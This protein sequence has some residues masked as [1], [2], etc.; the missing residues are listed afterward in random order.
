MVRSGGLQLPGRDGLPGSHGVMVE[1]ERGAVEADA[2]EPVV[3]TETTADGVGLFAQS[4]FL[5][6]IPQTMAGRLTTW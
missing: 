5:E 6:A 4:R 3:E 1:V 2:I